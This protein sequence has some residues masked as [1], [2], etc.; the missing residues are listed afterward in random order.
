MHS[1]N[2]DPMKAKTTSQNNKNSRLGLKDL[3]LDQ[4]QQ[5]RPDLAGPGVSMH[6]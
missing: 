6:R 3:V 2:L 5:H 4:F 1:E